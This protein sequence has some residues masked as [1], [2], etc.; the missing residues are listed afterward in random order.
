MTVYKVLFCLQKHIDLLHEAF[1]NPR[2]RL[3]HFFMMDKR[4]LLDFYCTIEYHPFTAII[5][6]GRARTFF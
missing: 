3:E 6:L 1:I 4:S 2:S 5:I